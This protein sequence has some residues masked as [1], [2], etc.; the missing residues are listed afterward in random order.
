[1]MIIV[2]IMMITII[3]TVFLEE[4][5]VTRR[6]YCEIRAHFICSKSIVDFALH[7]EAFS[8]FN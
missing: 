4:A 1:M 8:E 2:M 6:A 3:I 7:N 5:S